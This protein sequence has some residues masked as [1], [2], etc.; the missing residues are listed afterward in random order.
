M[1]Q[2]KLIYRIA[3]S[4]EATARELQQ[5]SDFMKARADAASKPGFKSEPNALN[6]LAEFAHVILNSNEFVYI[7]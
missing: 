3:Y 5:A 6:P 2:V 7:N 4:R 1:A